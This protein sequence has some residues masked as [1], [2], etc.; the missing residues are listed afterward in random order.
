MV[1]TT[2]FHPFPRLA[3]ELRVMIWAFAR[4]HPRIV[5]VCWSSGQGFS[6]HTAPSPLLRVCA[7]SQAV[8]LDTRYNHRPKLT[9]NNRLH[10]HTA[11][12]DGEGEGDGESESESESGRN[13][14]CANQVHFDFERD[15]LYFSYPYLCAESYGRSLKFFL[16][17]LHSSHASMIRHM[18]IALPLHSSDELPIKALDIE[19]CTPLNSTSKDSIRFATKI[20]DRAKDATA[21]ELETLTLG[22]NDPVLGNE[23]VLGPGL[24][25]HFIPARISN[26]NPR[27][28]WKARA[29]Y[30][31]YLVKR[32][33]RWSSPQ[34]KVACV[35]REDRKLVGHK[36]GV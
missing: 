4:Q 26:E 19:S 2:T 17:R 24:V 10:P 29:D 1:S 36:F 14:H 23:G 34:V 15:T 13:T 21:L 33:T 3:P 35:I 22:F 30:I 9:I 31:E 16:V 5:E 12:D 28:L 6:F 25:S 11:E 20:L 8:A 32:F 18:A 7:E 27:E